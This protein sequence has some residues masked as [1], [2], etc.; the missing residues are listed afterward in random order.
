LLLFAGWLTVAPAVADNRQPARVIVVSDEPE[1]PFVRRLIAELAL[2]GYDVRLA[3][4]ELGAAPLRRILETSGAAA[5]IAVDQRRQTADVVVAGDASAPLRQE[6]ERLDPRR[7]ADTNAAVLAERFRA[8]LTELGIAPAGGMEEAAAVS[9]PEPAEAPPAVREDKR[10]WIAASLGIVEGGLGAMPEAGL[11]LRAFPVA[12]LSTSA[13]LKL[14]PLAVTVRGSEGRA[15]V[16][17]VSSG[18][19][20]DAHPMSGERELSFGAGA[21]LVNASM[22]GSAPAPLTG[23]NDSVLVPAAVLRAAA[24]LRQ[25]KRWLLELQLFAGFCA[26]RIGVRFAGREVAEF[27]QP[28]Y[29]AGFGGALG[30]F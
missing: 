14:A 16:T 9:L 18:I 1:A 21:L 13:T 12:W 4:R 22:S 30:V 11:E 20:I 15:D 7:H 28:F 17:L 2:F 25:G 27:G 24:Q 8:R 3:E 10:L 23:T 5:L 19:F 26:P 29:G 6:R